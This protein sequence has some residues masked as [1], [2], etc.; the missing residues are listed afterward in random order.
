MTKPRM[1]HE[2]LFVIGGWSG[3]SSTDIIETYDTRADQWLVCRPIDSGQYLI[4]LNLSVSVC[5]SAC[6]PVCLSV[7]L[8][9]PPV[10]SATR[11]WR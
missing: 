6:L 10:V 9:V 8:S 2:V 1:P 4:L 5:L 11:E 7:C 3:G